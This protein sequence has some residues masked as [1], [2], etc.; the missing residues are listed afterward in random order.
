MEGS[1]P[2]EAFGYQP[3]DAVGVR[4]HSYGLGEAKDNETLEPLVIAVLRWAD[5]SEPNSGLVFRMSPGQALALGTR[6]TEWAQR[7][8]GRH[9]EQ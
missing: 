4:L 3:S 5:K 8:D 1:D 7:A 9:W 6:L 2:L